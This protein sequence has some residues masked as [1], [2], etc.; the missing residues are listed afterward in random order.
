MTPVASILVTVVVPPPTEIWSPTSNAPTLATWML[1][2]PAAWSADS[3]V[4]E[5]GPLARPWQ[6]QVQ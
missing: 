1:V 5:S 3:A 4:F 6:V 2:A